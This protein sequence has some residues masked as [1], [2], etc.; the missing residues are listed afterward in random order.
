MRFGIEPHR[1]GAFPAWFWVGFVVVLLLP[2]ARMLGALPDDWIP[3]CQFL[4]ST[5]HPC[6]GCGITR[7]LMSL[8]RGYVVEAFRSHPLG[9]L[10]IAVVCVWVAFGLAARLVARDLRIELS[11]RGRWY[12]LS[13]VVIALML[14]WVYLWTRTPVLRG[15]AA[16]PARSYCTAHLTEIDYAAYDD[17]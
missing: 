5:G 8:S 16:R 4:L 12:L 7:M 14:N 15:R 10:T 6:P 1:P 2:F 9:F 13:I 11:P 17:P 3:R